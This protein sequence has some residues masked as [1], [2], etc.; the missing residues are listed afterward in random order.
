MM[1]RRTSCKPLWLRSC[2]CCTALDP[3]LIFV[4]AHAAASRLGAMTLALV[5]WPCSC[6]LCGCFH[7]LFVFSISALDLCMHALPPP[8]RTD[9]YICP[10]STPTNPHHVA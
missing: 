9:P 6:L 10:G 8:P 5:R 3:A 7:S 1:R 4:G 2:E